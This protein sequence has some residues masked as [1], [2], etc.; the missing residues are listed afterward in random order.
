MKKTQITPLIIFVLISFS[1]CIPY[2]L[3]MS[4]KWSGF[5][6]I[7]TGDSIKVT[8]DFKVDGQILT[9]NVQ[10]PDGTVDITDGKIID[11]LFSFTVSGAAE[12]EV[13]QTGKY[14]G[15]SVS[16]DL[17]IHSVKF[18]LKLTRMKD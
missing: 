6:R 12:G 10:G 2:F 14:Y 9:G 15:D 3:D 8:Y 7:P 4:G 1:F 5:M 16:T 18:H 11:S 17:V 13:H